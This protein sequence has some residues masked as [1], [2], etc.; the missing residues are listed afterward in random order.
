MKEIP[1]LHKSSR[2]RTKGAC[3]TIYFMRPIF[4][5]PTVDRD[6]KRKLQ[7]N[8]PHKH[9]YKKS[10][11]NLYKPI[12]TAYTKK[13]KHYDQVVLMQGMQ[14][15]FNI[16]PKNINYCFD[17][18]NNQSTTSICANTKR[19]LANDKSSQQI[20]TRRKTSLS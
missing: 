6:I 11:Q 10:P 20:L 7:M 1:I 4:L 19:H 12:S 18:L 5:L 17:G 2:K 16:N 3:F 9:R 14:D 15:W 8:I 13:I